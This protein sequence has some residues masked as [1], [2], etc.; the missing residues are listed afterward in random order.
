MRALL[1]VFLVLAAGA[2]GLFAEEQDLAAGLDRMAMDGKGRIFAY[3]RGRTDKLAVFEDGRWKELPLFPAGKP[4]QPRGLLGLRDGRV[5]SVWNTGK[6]EWLV[7]ILEGK[8]LAQ[9]IPFPWRLGSYDFFSMAQDS[10][11]RIWLSGG[12]PEV[13]RFDPSAGTFHTF[14]LAPLYTGAPMEKWSDVFFTE[15]QRG[16]LWLWTSRRG[17][18]FASL[19]GPVRIH[20]DALDLLT[21]IPG[22]TGRTVDCLLPRDKDSLWMDAHHDGLFVFNLNTLSAEPVPEPQ[23]KAFRVGF[24]GIFPFVKGFLVLSGYKS[25]FALWQFAE[26]KWTRRTTPDSVPLMMTDGRAPAYLDA[27]SG[28]LIATADEI[29]Y[30]P[31]DEEGTKLLNWRSGW[32][33]TRPAQFL[34]LGGDRF[35]ALSSGGATRWA[36]ADLNDLLAPRPL[37]DAVEIFPWFGWAVDSQDRIFT[38]LKPKSAV[39]DVWENGSWR[40]IPLPKERRNDFQSHIEIDSQNRI[41]VV[42]IES[43][44]PV[45]ILS[46]DL[47][48]WE[49]EPDYL[50]ALAKHCEDFGGFANEQSRLQPIAGP[51]GQI[52]FRTT[53][54]QI[55]HWNRTA[56]KTWDLFDIGSFAKNDRMCPPFFDDEGRLC[57]NTL[58]SDKTWKLGGD[59]KWTGEAKMPGI[60]DRPMGDAQAPERQALPKDF[61]PQDIK[62]PQVVADNL[63]V[64]WVA[65]NSNLYKYFKGRTVAVFD[66][67]MVHPFLKNPAIQSVRVDRFGYTWFQTG[68]INHLMLPP[69]TPSLPSFSVKSDS[70]GLASLTSL[71]S[72]SID[73][74]LDH[75]TWQTLRASEQTLGFLPSGDHEIEFR[76][77]TDHLDII[78]PISKQLSVS[79]PP[80]KQLDHLITLLRNGPDAMREVAIAG[81]SRQPAAAIPALENAIKTSDSWWLQAARQECER[82][83]ASKP[84]PQ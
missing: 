53:N 17:E 59:Q 19:P 66:G 54:W 8:Q 39:L 57:V 82:G 50:S 3:R 14:D 9:T 24:H 7:A 65:G 6:N 55:I 81:L 77:L 37:S 71:P 48:I 28:A 32:T 84:S 26:G 67:K 33:L 61:V 31:H 13:V 41:W 70:W 11:G 21:D 20:E 46:S 52:A 1:L 25:S 60:P 12:T 44:L 38:L 23:Q 74:R 79:C 36:V 64:T 47:K 30:V 42:C 18:R 62:Q 49:T 51:H 75:G 10:T 58:R 63:G 16:G 5:A 45:S 80:A 40:E 76:I 68:S 72:G 35:V 78:G 83:K 69:K 43:K 56:W 2:A 15:D 29:L 4:A 27:K 34:S 73:W 22:L